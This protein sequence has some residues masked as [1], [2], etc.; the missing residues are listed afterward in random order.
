VLKEIL[1]DDACFRE[2]EELTIDSE[3]EVG[4]QPYLHGRL[5]L[6][7]VRKRAPKL[8]FEGILSS[9][10]TRLSMIQDPSTYVF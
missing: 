1:E 4:V 5:F 10:P 9:P 7:E 3:N 2:I 6:V 8:S